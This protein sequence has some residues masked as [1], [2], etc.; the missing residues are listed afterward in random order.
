[1]HEKGT[2][3]LYMKKVLF[4]CLGNACR[5]QIAEAFAKVYGEGFIEAYSAG[6][7]PAGF[8][9]DKTIAV[10]DEVE[11]DLRGAASKP[12]DPVLLSQV[13]WLVTLSEEAKPIFPATSNHARKLH[14]S[15]DDPVSV[16]GKEERIFQAFRMTR[17]EIERRVKTLMD[18][19]KQS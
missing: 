6:V 17:D 9:H 7:K 12:I 4:I 13:D 8:V 19:I 11:I 16:F 15:I 2:W 5:S 3:H 18:Q 1:L 10:M 14:W